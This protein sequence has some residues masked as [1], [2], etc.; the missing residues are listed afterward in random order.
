MCK[1]D[2]ILSNVC[3]RY[4]PLHT[5]THHSYAADEIHFNLMAVVSDR[6]R[7]LSR[8]V[9]ALT[10]RRDVAAQ[11]VSTPVCVCVCGWGIIAQYTNGTLCVFDMFIM[12]EQYA[13]PSSIPRCTNTIETIESGIPPHTHTPFNNKHTV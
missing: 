7:E 2:H 4:P 1:C 12:R 11:R 3:I 6:K 13:A 8:R 9:T 5:H 10:E